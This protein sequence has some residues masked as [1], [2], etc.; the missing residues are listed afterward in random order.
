MP[1]TRVEKVSDPLPD[2]AQWPGLTSLP[3]KR[4]A[5]TED[6]YFREVWAEWAADAAA[7]GTD[8]GG[9]LPALASAAL[10]CA[11]PD[12]VAGRRLRPM[13]DYIAAHGFRVTAVAGFTLTRHAMRALWWHDWHVYP[14]ARLAFCTY[15]YTA[16][17]TL[18]FLL[19]DARPVPGVPASVRLSGLKGNAIAAR[20]TGG[21][22][23]SALAPPNSVLN[24]VHVPDEPADILREL[25]I[26]FDRPERRT[27]MAAIR[28]GRE[29]DAWGE[30]QDRITGLEQR[31]PPHD[32]DPVASLERLE[33][34]G[35]LDAGRVAEIGSWIGAGTRQPWDVLCRAIDPGHPA[36]DPWDL[37]AV[38]SALI[39][40]E[41]EG[42][43]GLLPG[44]NSRLWSG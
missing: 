8:A 31:H 7:D 25:G 28:N 26:L 20:R 38:A 39:P 43:G 36:L 14:P 21:D 1:Q 6:L 44:V 29:H 13:L 5:F 4:A 18:A 17:A 19:H 23:R 22:L 10:L 27:L 35:V 42:M 3:E 40:L 11:K 12:A 33:Q 2:D 34:A 41:R 9:A 16:T 37:I 32:L 24:F 15:W 30:A